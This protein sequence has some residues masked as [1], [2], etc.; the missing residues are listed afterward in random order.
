LQKRGKNLR[1][2]L[3]LKKEGRRGERTAG[4]SLQG[5]TEKRGSGKKKGCLAK[6]DADQG[7]GKVHAERKVGS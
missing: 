4:R 6:P 1:N 5:R 3:C 7:G 2:G